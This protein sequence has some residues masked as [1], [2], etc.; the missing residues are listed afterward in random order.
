MLRVPGE[1]AQ[2]VR[3][4]IQI[5]QLGESALLD[6]QLPAA[7]VPR[8]LR[9]RFVKP[10]VLGHEARAPRRAG[11]AHQLHQTP[12]VHPDLLA[13]TAHPKDGGRNIQVRDRLVA[14]RA[15]RESGAADQQRDSHGFLHHQA[16]LVA[17]R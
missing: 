3:I 7:R 15:L 17:D 4:G 5:V 9:H 12:P 10:V 6:N 1:I 14:G 13:D 11:L 16:S 8:A 2:L